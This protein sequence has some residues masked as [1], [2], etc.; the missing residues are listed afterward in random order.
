VTVP[1]GFILLAAFLLL[2][3]VGFVALFRSLYDSVEGYEDE[4]G[5]HQVTLSRCDHPEMADE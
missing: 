5:F 3:V 1:L 2:A 4:A